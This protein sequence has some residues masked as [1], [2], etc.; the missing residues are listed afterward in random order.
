MRYLFLILLCSLL[1]ACFGGGGVVPQDRFYHL[2]DISG[3]STHV[4][5]PFG[6][7]AVSP[8]QSD[9]LH[10]GR[11]ILYSLQSAP[12][13]LNTYYYHQW[14][15]VPGQMI[16]ENLIAYLRKL[17]FAR[18]VIRYGERA[19]IDAQ[20]NGHIQRFERIVGDGNPRVAVRLELSFIPRTAGEQH[21]ITK[22]YT[23]VRKTTGNSMEASV[24]AFSQALQAIYARF[25]ADVMR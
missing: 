24:A 4:S 14:S 8:L 16:Q 18:T 25:V 22:V 10:R 2:A 9:A 13:M 12:L 21:S 7:V 6:V 20:I 1:S 3:D 19:H 17:G 15:D 23:E 5:K 11:M